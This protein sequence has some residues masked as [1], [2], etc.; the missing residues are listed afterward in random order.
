MNWPRWW[1]WELEISPHIEKRMEERD[2]T[3]IDLRAMMHGAH[4]FEPDT[5]E[6]RY[7]IQTQH[8]H[9]DWKIIVEPDEED[10]L[11]VVVTAFPL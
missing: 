10:H 11:L 4:T 7:V 6:G 3:E 8:R 1:N 2:F 9:N 5:I